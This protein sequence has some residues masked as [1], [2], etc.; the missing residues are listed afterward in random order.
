MGIPRLRLASRINKPAKLLLGL[1]TLW[2]P[3]YLAVFVAF[4]FFAAFPSDGNFPVSFTAMFRLHL[5]TVFWVWSLLVIYLL[6][7]FR[8]DQMDQD[9]KALWAIVLFLGNMIVLPVYWY[10]FVW[11]SS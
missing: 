9:K 5:I 11:R 6:D 4:A 2:P 10:L 8:N 3:I 7:V 1:I